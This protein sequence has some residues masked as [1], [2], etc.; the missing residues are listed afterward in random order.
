M[1]A[2]IAANRLEWVT[3]TQSRFSDLDWGKHT[4]R[5]RDLEALKEIQVDMTADEV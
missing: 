5:V 2:Q 3:D 1:T 4:Y